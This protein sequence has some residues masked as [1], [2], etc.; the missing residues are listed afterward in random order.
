MGTPDFAVSSLKVLVENDFDVVG[1]ITATDKYGGRGN[2]T[3][4][5]SPV[6]KYAASQNLNILQP[7]NLKNEDFLS[8]LKA[9]NADLQIVVAFR[10]LPVAV[11]D[12]PPLGTFNL[13]GSLLPKYRGA[14]P[15]HWAVINGE[16]ETGVTTFFLKHKIDTGNILYQEKIAIKETDTTGDVH[17]ALMEV[18]AQLVLKTA[19]DI[20]NG[21]TI[22][23][24]EQDESLVCH[25]PK[26]FSTNTEIDFDNSVEDVYNLIR[27]LAPFPTAWTKL[28]DKKLKVYACEKEIAGHTVELGDLVT[29]NKSYLKFA[30][31]NGFVSVTDIQWQGKKRMKIKDFLNGV[32]L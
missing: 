10:M 3:L 17:D 8:E 7:K 24:K 30:C 13:H 9:L 29:D 12:M 25:A 31:K 26:L 2:K 21:I 11:W 20:Q 32:S 16:V 19:T 22:I 1:V 14:A 18:G 15:I 27:G 6:K 4:L 5:E 28:Q 23:P